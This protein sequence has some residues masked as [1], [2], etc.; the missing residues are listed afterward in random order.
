[1]R[2]RSEMYLLSTCDVLLTSGF[3]TFGYVV[4]GLA[5]RR[6]WV[7]ARSPVW[8]KDWR[9]ELDTHGRSC[10]RVAS[11]EPCFLSPS[12]YNCVAGRDVDL[13]K[14]KPYIKRCVD[15]RWGIKLVNESSRSSH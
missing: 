5:G 6:P 14:V 1:M 9:E 3:S 8:A 11:V 4:Q 10:R 15:V 7:M 13:D 2:V 12:A